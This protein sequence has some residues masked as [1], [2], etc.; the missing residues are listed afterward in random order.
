MKPL[1][2]ISALAMLLAL[3]WP[4]AAIT[5]ERSVTLTVDNM[6]CATCPYIVRKA[7]ER[8]DGVAQATASLREGTA[9]VIFDDEQTTVDDLTRATA[10][11][12]F[13]SRLKDQVG[14]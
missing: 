8:V 7:L 4:V 11:A 13:P 6:T 12:G 14:D 1:L 9:V 5:A 3:C 10:D 2:R